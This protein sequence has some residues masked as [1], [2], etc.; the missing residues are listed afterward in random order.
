MSPS[1]PSLKSLDISFT[2]ITDVGLEHLASLAQ[3]EELNLGRQQDQRREPARAEAAAQAQE[4][5]FLRHPAAQCR[6]VLGAG[7]HRPG[8]RDHLA[9]RRARGSEYRLRRG[10]RDAAADRSRDR[11]MARRNAASPAAL[12]ITDLGLARLVEARE[13]PAARSE[14]RRDHRERLEDSREPAGPAASESVERQ[15]HRR[16]ARRRTSRRSAT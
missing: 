5:E 3:L 2:Q 6:V 13:A 14:R 1:S 10:A 11:P 9:A 16:Y 4:A 8:A 7:R 15:G 12:R